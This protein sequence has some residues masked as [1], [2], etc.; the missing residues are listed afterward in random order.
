MVAPLTVYGVDYELSYDN[1]IAITVAPDDTITMN[2][3]GD[4]S[5]SNADSQNQSGIKKIDMTIDIKVE[6]EDLTSFDS[7]ISIQL[8]PSVYSQLAN[9]DLELVAHSD[10]AETN[11][12]AFLDYPGYLGIEGS[13]GLVIVESPFKFILDVMLETKLYYSMY[14]REELQM[15]T[16]NIPMLETQLS[17]MVME[18]SD[19]NIIV[20]KFE[21]LEYEEGSEYASFT[22]S[23]R[24]SGDL[25]EVL[26]SAIDE[27]RAELTAQEVPE[28]LPE[29]SIESIDYYVS[30]SGNSLLFDANVGGVVAG[31]FDIELNK[32]KDSTLEE[33]LEN[34][35]LDGDERV[36]VE[37][38][39]EINLFVKHLVIESSVSYE[40]E[41]FESTFSLDGLGLV[42]ES[43]EML[44]GFLEGLSSNED[45]G[46]LKLVLVGESHSN[47]YVL[48]EL[49]ADIKEPMLQEDQ[50]VVWEMKGVENLDEVTY[51]VV[52]GEIEALDGEMGEMKSSQIPGFPYT[53]I[54]IGI[55]ATILLQIHSQRTCQTFW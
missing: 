51:E 17:S 11:I 31:D 46:D 55:L 33:A 38:A 24:L 53:S 47:L 45:Y 1:Y 2:L 28:E 19:G 41:S 37:R 14:P 10:E 32:F 50:L 42:P 49:S 52:A 7:D 16:A 26:T 18:S 9:L 13:L 29:L 36:L 20:E 27:Y 39:Q 54:L 43:F 3:K 4:Q 12:T 23:M 30:F 35:E 25:Q 48:F 21:L 5:H 40:D 34:N 22:V 15:L 6:E 8:D 44:M